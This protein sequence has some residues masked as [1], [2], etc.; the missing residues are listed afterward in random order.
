MPPHYPSE[1]NHPTDLSMPPPADSII[2]IDTA[3]P[4]SSSNHSDVA[5]VLRRNQACLQCRKRKLARPHCATCVRSYR[6]LL[7]TSPKSDPVLCCDYDDGT[8]H[9]HDD[10]DKA[11]KGSS[12]KSPGQG[13]D[14]DDGGG[15]KKRKAS[16]EGRR[17]KKD[18]EFEEERDRLTK[19][20]E[21]LQAQLTHKTQAQP[22]S[23]AQPQNIPQPN[24]TWSSAAQPLQETLSADSPTAFLEMLS[25]AASTQAHGSFSSS[26]PD[27]SSDGP[28]WGNINRP[29]DLDTRFKPMFAFSHDKGQTNVSGLNDPSPGDQSQ[30]QESRRSSLQNLTPGSNGEFS[31]QGPAILSPGGVF[32][33]SPPDTTSTNFMANWPPP[34]DPL[35]GNIEPSTKIDGPWRGVETIETV[36]AAGMN[37]AN[38]PTFGADTNM[39]TEINLD[40]LQ[41]GLDAAMQ[42]Q[43]LMDLFWPGWPSNLPEPNVVND[44]IEAFFD[45][46]PNL[47]RVLHRARFL[48]RMA[49]PPTHSNFPHPALIHAVCAAAAAWCPPE[50]YEKS[51]RG[52]GRDFFD[53]SG[54]GMYGTDG[55]AG[56]ASKMTLTF[57]LRQASFAKE[58]VQEGL[59]TGN[60]L[61]DVVRAMI[62]LCRVFIDDTRML[63]C[64]A[65]G[66]L[67]ARMLLPL[68]LNVR[69]AELSLKS[70]MLPPPADALERE[71]RRAAVWMAF[72]HDT[73]SS[74]ASGWGTSMSLDELTVPLPV[75]NKDFEEGHEQ[76][77]PNPQDLESPDFWVK[78]P[79][80]D[81]WVMC[82]KATVLMNRVTKF[83]RRW[84]NRH[85]R[86]NDDFD[87]L[88]RPEF[89]EIANAIACF[90]MSFPPSLR[91]VGKLTSKKILDIDLIA[92]HMLPHAAII[93]LHEPFADLTDPSDQAARRMLGATQGIVSIVQQ[94]ASVVGAGGSNFTSVMHSSASVCLVTSARTSLLF[95]RHALNVGDMAA[96]QSHRTDCEMIRMALSQFGLKFKIGHHHSQLIEYFL[97][98]ATNPT[99]EKLQAHYPD[100]PR[101]GAPELTPNANF[102]LCVAN[103]L[104]IKRGFWRLNKTSASTGASPF[105]STPDSTTGIGR[106]QPSS[107]SSV[108]HHLSDNDSPIQ[109]PLEALGLRLNANQTKP[110]TL[111]NASSEAMET[112]S[113]P[114][115]D[116]NQNQSRRQ[117]SNLSNNSN[118][119]G[120]FDANTGLQSD[121]EPPANNYNPHGLC[122]MAAAAAKQPIQI[123][124]NQP[125]SSLAQQTFAINAWKEGQ[126]ENDR[127]QSAI[128]GLNGNNQPSG[129]AAPQTQSGSG[130]GSNGGAHINQDQFDASRAG[131]R[132]V[133][134][135]MKD[136]FDNAKKLTDGQYPIWMNMTEDELVAAARQLER[137]AQV[138]KEKEQT[139]QSQSQPFD[140]SLPGI[141]P[142]TQEMM[143]KIQARGQMTQDGTYPVWMNTTE[144]ELLAEQQQRQNIKITE[145]NL[146][147]EMENIMRNVGKVGKDGH[148]AYGFS[149]TTDQLIAEQMRSTSNS[150]N[151][152]NA[153][154]TSGIGSNIAQQSNLSNSNSNSNTN[155]LNPGAFNL[156]PEVEDKFA[157]IRTVGPD[158]HLHVMQNLTQEQIMNEISR[159]A[160]VPINVGYKEGQVEQGRVGEMLRRIYE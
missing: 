154:N 111:R 51:T 3:A 38:Q 102:G 59:N 35:T 127:D 153:R 67:V 79:V 80:P 107:S 159:N 27:G 74:A 112:D 132:P 39:D 81:S 26:K 158:G 134:A 124:G 5:G 15:K 90:Q 92:A 101:S 98:R 34:P 6:H 30:S 117:T 72:Y 122:D 25:S 33:F 57:G 50:I 21:E 137:E 106:P 99:F 18:E 8:G 1:P 121:S 19:K 54:L 129:T 143:D 58:A 68:G 140:M 141:T 96:A 123:V 131:I 103:A 37:S 120:S 139:A 24:R 116:S 9:G 44:L 69:S 36:F 49:L 95:L 105:G 83:A 41:A 84:K 86:D 23:A 61:F 56:K 62:I 12:S 28:F 138:Q 76:M 130:V 108:S 20:I 85:M 145:P 16:G 88:N 144:Q 114:N 133:T 155:N 93:C 22:S 136:K 43:L 135:E 151:N 32:N 53:S 110:A 147:P 13:P 156:N 160:Q 152:G 47:P 118:N 115:T 14:D 40:G 148:I 55:L 70:V 66:G 17:K 52:K 4:A 45:L 60:R 78:H 125:L 42:Q 97:D 71:E 82:V 149:T 75:S 87:G 10:G 29:I 100:H 113:P 91:N 46:V 146:S 31:S 150:N 73:I 48:S 157:K 63:E 7:R 104:N 89:R 126:V 65:Y 109:H 11:E 142:V 94:L 2:H 119:R 128:D 64:W 77:E